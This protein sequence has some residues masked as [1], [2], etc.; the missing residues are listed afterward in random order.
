MHIFV[1][2]MT[3][4]IASHMVALLHEQGHK[5]SGVDNFSNS[6]IESLER[7]ETLCETDLVFEEVDVCNEERLKFALTI[8]T[9]V[10]GPIDA[11]MH[12]A[13]L[14]AVG[15]SSKIPL[16][17]YQTNIAGTLNLLGCMRDFGIKQFVFSSSA[18]VYGVPETTPLHEG[19]RTQSTNPYGRS[20]LVI[21][22]L[23]EDI[24]AADP[25]MRIAR[26]RYFNPV[27]AHPSGLIGELPNG[28]PNNLMPYVFKVATGELPQVNVF[29]NDYETKDGTGV[30]DYIH[31][32]DLVSGHL[33]A[34]KHLAKNKGLFT[35]NL[36]TGKGYSVLEM[37]QRTEAITGIKI[38]YAISERRP[39]DVGEVYADAS[40][41]KHVLNWE[42]EY[43]LDDMIYHQWQWARKADQ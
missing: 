11:V 27:G 5:V 7:L 25:E 24:A 9:K 26:L 41:A 28:I 2:G 6:T 36:G 17:Y 37:I 12:F 1:T 13:G 3:G 34:V 8:A 40:L 21:E 33:S 30:R 39:G 20:K 29:G 23:L 15:E 38:P 32:C 35:F 19:C 14:K 31:V 16:H 18:T 4:Y 42:A 10:N 43:N 22:E